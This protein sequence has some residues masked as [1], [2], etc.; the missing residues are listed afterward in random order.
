MKKLIIAT[1]SILSVF[2]FSAFSVQ[3]QGVSTS[4]CTCV[5]SPNKGSTDTLG[6]IWLAVGDVLYSGVT[7]F[8]KAASGDPLYPGSQMS[9][10]TASSAQIT[11]GTSCELHI[12]ANSEVNISQPAGPGTEICVK[13]SDDPVVAASKPNGG[14]IIIPLAIALGIGLNQ[15]SN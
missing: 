3:A 7:G 12:P 10:S 15:A 4:E 5:T 8:E 2:N 11:V 6:K 1:V 13:V 9:V 14:A